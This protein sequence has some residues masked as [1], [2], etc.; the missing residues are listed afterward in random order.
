MSKVICKNKFPHL[1]TI[2]LLL[3]TKPTI[4][5]TN[6]TQKEQISREDLLNHIF[7]PALT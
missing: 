5:K 3:L 7:M 1:L 2:Y 6:N 4:T